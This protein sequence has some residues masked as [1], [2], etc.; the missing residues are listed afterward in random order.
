LML[1]K[2]WSKDE[3]KIE[4]SMPVLEVKSNPLVRNNIGKIA[5]QRGPIIYCLE[6]IDNGENLAAIYLK[7]DKYKVKTEE[8]HLNNMVTIETTGE[9]IDWKGVD[10][11]YSYSEESYENKEMKVKAVPYFSWNNRGSGEMIVWIN[12]NNNE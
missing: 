2:K 8:N 5:L 1:N 4:F 7:E 6:E 12:K 11:N 10:K 3:I 9:K